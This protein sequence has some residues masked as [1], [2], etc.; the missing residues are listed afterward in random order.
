MEVVYFYFMMISRVTLIHN[1][2]LTIAVK[3]DSIRHL[4]L[5]K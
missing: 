2:Y 3:H 1:D 5:L 4:V